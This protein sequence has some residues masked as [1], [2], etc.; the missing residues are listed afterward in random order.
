MPN[1]NIAFA[2]VIATLIGALFHLVM[3]GRGRRLLLFLVSAW[4]G[5]ALGNAAGQVLGVNIVTI[6]DLRI[7]PASFGALFTL[8]VAHILTT[9]RRRTR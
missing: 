8:F 1:P 2:F 5:F 4:V 6:G 3:G 9:G 7:L